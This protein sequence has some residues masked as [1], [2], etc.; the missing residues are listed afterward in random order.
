MAQLVK[1]NDEY[2]RDEAFAHLRK[3][4]N[5]VPGAGNTDKPSVMLIGEAP[6]EEEAEKLTPFVGKA[7]R[8]LDDMLKR[9]R[10]SRADTYVTNVIKYRPT[11][12][13]APTPGEIA[14]AAPY[15]HREI[16]SLDP[17]I[18]VPLGRTAL[19]ML[20]PGHGITEARGKFLKV[21]W[22]PVV[23]VP[24]YHPAACLRDTD[25]QVI[26]QSDLTRLRVL[27]NQVGAK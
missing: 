23:V 7:G 2:A 14:A 9:A 24:M 5:L 12:N 18:I 19:N 3:H 27:M 10:I 8:L 17:L 4:A 26:T 13:R 22:S 16:L 11:A 21:D 20:F 1:I 6:G 25:K 15:L